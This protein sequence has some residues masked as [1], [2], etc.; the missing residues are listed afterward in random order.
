MQTFPNR[1][2]VLCGFEKSDSRVPKQIPTRVTAREPGGEPRAQADGCAVP[3]RTP[4]T[5]GA[6]ALA[7]QSRARAFG[8]D[9]RTVLLRRK[10]NARRKTWP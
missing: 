5:K 1:R 7:R 8:P 9:Y 3:V 6:C 2:K 10:W 4:A